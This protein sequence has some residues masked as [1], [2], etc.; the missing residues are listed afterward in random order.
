MLWKLQGVKCVE[1]FG[2]EFVKLASEFIEILFRSFLVAIDDEFE[3]RVY[4]DGP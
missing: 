3:K 2:V 1:F 4:E